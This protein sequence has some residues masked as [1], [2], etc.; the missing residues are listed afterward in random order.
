[1][2]REVAALVGM[3]SWLPADIKDLTVPYRRYWVKWFTAMHDKAASDK[4]SS[5]QQ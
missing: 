5:S 4:M 2:Q 3:A 1:M